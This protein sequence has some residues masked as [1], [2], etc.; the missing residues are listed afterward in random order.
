MRITALTPMPTPT[1]E[2]IWAELQ[3]SGG[4]S[5]QRRID[6]THPLDL[7]AD[8][9]PP[10]KP[11]LVAVCG[12]LPPD[13]RPLRALA[14]EHGQRSDGRWALR[15]SLREPRLLAVFAALCRDIVAVTRSGIDERRLASA[16]L[17]R[18]DHWRTLLER[19]GAGLGE[20]TLRGLIGELLVFERHVLAVL[21]LPE[22][23]AAWTGPQGSPQ[24]FKLPSGTRIE[25]KT[26]GRD[27]GT[28]RVNGLDQLDTGADPLLLAVVRVETTGASAPDAVTVPALIA[29]L[30]D[31][32]S[33]DPD[34][35]AKFDEALACV[36]WHDDPSHRAFAVRVIAIEAYEVGPGFPRLTRRSVPAGVE[37]A[38]YTI[39][40]PGCSPDVAKVET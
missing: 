23:V 40:L 8:F 25:V 20:A 15:L 30:R 39:V 3:T 27:A 14:L 9:D 26:I 13:C 38:Q 4:G 22:A 33:A 17:G 18:L 29:G 16:V 11:G 10:D 35:L 6:S 31:R 5:R 19:D 2:Q 12:I 1:I 7:Y 32:I 37:N 21:S 24:D 34:A 36:G 28:V